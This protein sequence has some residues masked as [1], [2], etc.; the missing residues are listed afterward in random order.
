MLNDSTVPY[1]RI[2]TAR[3]VRPAPLDA[4]NL[5][6]TKQRIGQLAKDFGVDGRQRER[7]RIV[8]RE[9]RVIRFPYP[10][11]V[12]AVIGKIRRSGVRVRP[13]VFPPQRRKPRTATRSQVMVLVNGRLCTIQFRH[14]RK[15]RPEGR[16]YA[17]FD[18]NVRVR[19]AEFA[20]WALRSGRRLNITQP[21]HPHITASSQS[22]S[23]VRLGR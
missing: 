7:E 22:R 19:K 14:G 20:L 18:T 15:L 21:K 12:R 4:K 23:A 16:E 5:G 1:E 9:L 8:R 2:A 13:Y 11:D 6:L 17:R 10:P 3:G